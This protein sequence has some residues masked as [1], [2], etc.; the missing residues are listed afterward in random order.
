M[1]LIYEN[2]ITEVHIILKKN[3]KLANRSN[4]TC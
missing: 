2:K 4:K 3:N 1:C